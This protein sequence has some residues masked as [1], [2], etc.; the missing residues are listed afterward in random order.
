MEISRYKV[1]GT[2]K[3]QATGDPSLRIR[4]HCLQTQIS[5]GS[6]PLCGSKNVPLKQSNLGMMSQSKKNQA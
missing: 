2:R 4:S 3:L 6:L 1:R 5:R